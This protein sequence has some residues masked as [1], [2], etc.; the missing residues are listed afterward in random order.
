M[1]MIFIILN[2]KYAT[3]TD[4]LEQMSYQSEQKCNV[5]PL[6]NIQVSYRPWDNTL[7]Q[8][9]ISCLVRTSFVVNWN[10]LIF[11]KPLNKKV[12]LYLIHRVGCETTK[13]F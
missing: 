12:G 9:S 1:R 6:L 4:L 7:S 13:T 2:G 5:A 11:L 8:D 10:G 3:Y